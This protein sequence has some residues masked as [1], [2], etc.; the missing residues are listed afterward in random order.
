MVGRTML[1]LCVPFYEL[2]YFYVL[3]LMLFAL[4]FLLAQHLHEVTNLKMF[5]L[6]VD[7]MISNKWYIKGQ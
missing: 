4:K 6:L 5:L 7:K 1:K 3:E 2:F